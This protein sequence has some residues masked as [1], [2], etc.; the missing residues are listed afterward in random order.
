MLIDDFFD[1]DASIVAKELLGKVLRVKYQNVWLSAMIIE[2]EAYYRH[3]KGSHA[4]LGYTEKRKALFMP[5]GTIYMYHAHGGDSLNISCHGPGN[6]VLIKSGIVYFDKKTPANMLDLMQQLNSKANGEKRT[7]TRLCSGQTLLCKSLGLKVKI[8][9]QKNFDPDKF[10]IEGVGYQPEKIIQTRRLGIPK[11]RD[12]HLMLRFIDLQHA[13]HCTSNPLTKRIYRKGHEYK[14]ILLHS[15]PLKGL[16]ILITRP[17][18]QAKTLT[19]AIRLAGGKPI[20]YPTIAINDPKDNTALLTALKNLS[21]FDIAIFTSI[22]AVEKTLR[23]WQRTPKKLLLGAI[24]PTTAKALAQ[25]RLKTS[26]VATSPYSSETL[27]DTPQLQNIKHKHIVIFTGEDGRNFLAETLQQRGATV[28][29]A[30]AYRRSLP[31][32]SHAKW[33]I[34]DINIIFSS[35]YEGLRNLLLLQEKQKHRLM[36]IPLLVTSERLFLLA[37]ELG[38]ATI[39]VAE[40]TGD[41]AVLKSLKAC[42]STQLKKELKNIKL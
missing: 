39:F 3:E 9:D 17:K 10:Y 29:L 20:L 35:S 11:G 2:T 28:T 19:D 37:K 30:F 23:Y 25:Y 27:L 7:E 8:W 21:N 12:E 31:K 18:Q 42:Y 40:N 33:K 24:G 14:I 22:N 1:R 41:E 4:W 6:A 16:Q 38:F 26:F 15:K 36:Q 5:A 13:S 32:I 34:E